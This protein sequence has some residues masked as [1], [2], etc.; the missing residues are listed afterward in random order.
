MQGRGASRAVGLHR[1][2]DAEESIELARLDARDS[3]PRAGEVGE[4][5]VARERVLEYVDLAQPLERIRV[6]C[7]QRE[8][9]ILGALALLE[10][11][12]R[13]GGDEVE[14]VVDLAVVVLEPSDGVD[15]I[16]LDAR[17]HRVVVRRAV[18]VVAAV[19]RRRVLLGDLLA[20]AHEDREHCA[21]LDKPVGVQRKRYLWPTERH[22]VLVRVDHVDEAVEAIAV[23]AD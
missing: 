1:T 10:A 18:H 23:P 12:E 3:E 7:P 6:L 9:L 13:S 5:R 4:E 16:V 19:G 20:D 11:R 8:Q 15:L 2:D 22:R 17:D 14:S 21:V